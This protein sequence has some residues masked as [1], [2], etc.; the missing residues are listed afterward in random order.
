M[1]AHMNSVLIHIQVGLFVQITREG[2]GVLLYKCHHWY[3]MADGVEVM[4]VCDRSI[5][6]VEG[7]PAVDDRLG[8]I[9]TRDKRGRR[10]LLP[11]HLDDG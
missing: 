6:L 4:H 2:D 5:P 1:V 10:R 8:G 3:S 11:L 7:T 9:G